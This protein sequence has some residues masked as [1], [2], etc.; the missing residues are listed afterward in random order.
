M[1]NE[2]MEQ[3]TTETAEEARERV[4]REATEM[5]VNLCRGKMNLYKPIRSEGKDISMVSF[6]FDNLTN[7][8]LLTALDFDRNN[9]GYNGISDR[10]CL[11]L[12]G[13]TAAKETGNGLDWKDFVKQLHPK[14]TL[15]AIDRARFF[16][17]AS[18]QTGGMRISK[19]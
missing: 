12:F 8:E 6:D 10:Q 11:A 7:T 3:K 2:Q 16:Y 19:A 4:I 17:R 15:V 13:M 1:E 9:S 14:D 18:L 5:A